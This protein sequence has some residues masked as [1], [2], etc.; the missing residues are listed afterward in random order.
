MTSAPGMSCVSVGP[1][2]TG[3]CVHVCR[4]IQG[5][6]VCRTSLTCSCSAGHGVE[7][8]APLSSG[9]G[10]TPRIR[11]PSVVVFAV[12][13]ANDG[14]KA[15]HV[16]GAPTTDVSRERWYP[17]RRSS[18]VT[19]R[20]STC[21]RWPSS[22]QSTDGSG[23]LFD[24]DNLDRTVAALLASQGG[25]PGRTAA[26]QR[27][28]EAET[29]LRR[30]QAAIAAGV[31]PAA[32]IDAINQ[33]QALRTAAQNELDSRSAPM[34][35]TEA[36][37]RAMVG[38]LGDIGDALNRAEPTMLGSL[39]EALRMEAVYDAGARVVTVTIRPAHVA[40]TCVR[41]GT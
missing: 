15:L 7:R 39:Y 22:G 35:L 13:T 12:A 29:R 34:S 23:D 14:W 33:A 20:A 1:D 18:L 36:G 11:T 4:P 27:L 31:D 6:S 5:L 21:R 3:L 38:A 41:G 32:L 26:G 16:G 10:R 30:F 2:P 25:D 24:P 8:P 40:K 9:P 28:K 17:A 37:V 19:R